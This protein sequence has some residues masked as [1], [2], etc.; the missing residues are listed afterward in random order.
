MNE[1]IKKRKL[2]LDLDK[3]IWNCYDKNSNQIWAKQLV[4]PFFLSIDNNELID[5]VGGV[6]RLKEGFRAFVEKVF[7]LDLTISYLSVG[8][9]LEVPLEHQPSFLAL[10]KFQVLKYFSGDN[11]L[12]YKT[13]KKLNYF[14]KNYIYLFIDDSDEILKSVNDLEYVETIDAKVIKSWNQVTP[15]VQEFI[16]TNYLERKVKN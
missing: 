16:N 7:D 2:I 3:T 1:K 6:C 8:A 4:P 10:K 12:L 5:D 15:K 14:N 11:Y 9:R 13:K